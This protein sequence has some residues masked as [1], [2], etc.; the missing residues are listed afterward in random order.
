MSMVGRIC[1]T[2]SYAPERVMDNDELSLIVDTSD[3]WIRER[4]G[5]ERR[6]IAEWETTSYMAIE[7]ARDAVRQSGIAVEDIDLILL[8][9]SSP[10]TVFPCVACEVQKAIG[11]ENAV[12][13]DLNA[14]CSGFVLAFQAA[15][16][17]IMAGIYKTVLVIGAE[18]MSS[19][20]DWT[21][22]GTCILFGDGAGAVL[23]QAEDGDFCYMAAHSDGGKGDALKL[24]GR[25]GSDLKRLQ[26]SAEEAK[27]QSV[28]DCSGDGSADSA[29]YIQMNGQEVFRFA[30]RKEPE[31]IE[32][33]LT[34]SGLEAGDIDY[35]ILH[36]ANSR[37]I[38][39]IARRLKVPIERFPMNLAEYANT[40]SA[41]IPILLDEMNREGRLERGQKLILSGFGAGLTWAGCLIEW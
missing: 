31:I 17:H 23:L 9:T 41:T 6:H 37:I 15:Q 25:R 8:A 34:K 3:A 4:T 32:E 28:P 14:A 5:I 27:P 2:G 19:V 7:A 21:D 24:D 39:A 18:T 11:A 26:S 29:P 12:G 10:D 38:D 16:A 40:S 1:G 36:Q 20:I 33:L 13:Y 35:F 30:V 22:R